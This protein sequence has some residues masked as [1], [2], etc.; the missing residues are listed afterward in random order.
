MK[1]KLALHILKKGKNVLLTG[2]AGSG[3]TFVLNEFIRYLKRKKIPAGIT[4]PTGVAAT[5]INGRTLHSWAGLGIQH[6]FG[7]REIDKIVYNKR[8]RPRVEKARIL[9]IDE[10]SMMNDYHL[11]VLDAICRKIRMSTSP[12]GGIQ[13]VMSGDFFQLSPISRDGREGNFVNKAEV[14]SQM[15]LQVCYLTEQHRHDDRDLTKILNEIRQNRV[16]LATRKLLAKRKRAPL[17]DKI[18]ATRLYTHNV[19]VDAQNDY[20]LSLIDGKGYQYEMAEAG[21]ATLGKGLKKNCLA[22]E[23]LVLKKGALV[24]FLKNNPDEGYV[25]GTLGKVIGFSPEEQPI[26]ETALGDVITVSPARWVIEEDDKI[27]AQISQVPLRLAWAIT[28]HKSQGMTL[29]L[30]EM[31]LSRTFAPG[32][33]YVALSRVRQLDSLS[34][35]GIN[36]MAY[37]VNPKAVALDKELREWAIET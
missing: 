13:V 28:V 27:L 4:A 6:T 5:H 21:Q 35:L 19:D 12:F 29:D 15:D 7:K 11:D 10:I 26:V 22:P 32:M 37:R 31:D 2:P 14:W 1:Q 34:L 36:E 9:I 3:K 20:Q 16:S 23:V 24:M 8:I 33:G 17:A 18:P 25:N 30:A